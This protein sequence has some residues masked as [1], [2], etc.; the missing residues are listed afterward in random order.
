MSV[1]QELAKY[2]IDSNF[3]DLPSDVVEKTKRF[4]LDTLG[5]AIGGYGSDTSRIIQEVIKQSNGP[6]GATVIGS[7]LKTSCL[8]AALANG[9]MARYLDYND[10]AFIKTEEEYRTDFHA[11]EVIPPILALGERVHLSGKEVITNIVLG[12][13]LSF[14]FL[15]GIVGPGIEQRGWNIDTRA[16]YIIPLLAGKI[17][18]LDDTQ[19]ENA[20]G[21]SASCHAVFGILDSPSE[22]LTM[23][24]NIRFPMMAYG[25]I[26]GAMLAQR[27]FTGPTR[28]IEG[29]DGFVEVI[30]KGDYDLGKLTDMKRR[31]T[32][33]DC[34]SIKSI[35]A[36]Y[37]THGHLSATLKLVREHDIKPDDVAEIRI[38]TSNRCVHHTG[39]LAKKYPRNKETAD[40][41]SYYLTAIAVIDRQLGTEQFSAEKYSYPKVLEL[42]DKIVLEG[43]KEFDKI[44][45]AGMTEIV[46][47]QGQRYCCRVDYPKGHPLNP[48]DDD[49]IVEKFQSLASKYM[50]KTRMGQ[51]IKTVFD[52]DKLDDIGKL[53]RLM[54]FKCR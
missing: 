21:I 7:G 22:E 36:D 37:S 19:M 45:P 1:A 47:K 6:R 49:E 48:M 16:A 13:D 24:K 34:C 46:T 15:E 39:D 20:I 38:K 54:T 4:L 8:N 5:C 31:F 23:T 9:A 26:I 44:R 14:R 28:M 41:S 30:M 42:I 3:Q 53:N 2:V 27:G 33:R 51:V 40:H 29:H 43:D 12:Y 11:S 10:T 35:I 18:G 25:A 52:L 50:S 32:V 17:L